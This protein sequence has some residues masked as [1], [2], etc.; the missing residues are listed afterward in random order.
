MAEFS[1]L[2][3]KMA[4]FTCN[5]SYRDE[6]NKNVK[7]CQPSAAD[8][9]ADQ[10]IDLRAEVR[11]L[12]DDMRDGMRVLRDDVRGDVQDVR[13][14]VVAVADAIQRLD[15]QTASIKAWL[16]ANE[17]RDKTNVDDVVFL[18][19]TWSTQMFELVAEDNAI[20][21][22]LYQLDRA[23]ADERVDLTTFLRV[24]RKL[25]HTQFMA[26]ALAV[27]VVERQREEYTKG[28]YAQSPQ[29][30]SVA[31]Q[32]RLSQPGGPWPQVPP[33]YAIQQQQF[34]SQPQSQFQ[35]QFQQHYP[36]QFQ[37]PYAQPIQ[38]G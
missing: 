38:V 7:K 12:R 26:R 11:I 30:S 14:G 32:A 35:P 34:Q 13:D 33:P 19:D 2:M 28:A 36:P 25:A 20:E 21:D 22:T 18:K 23:L 9:G 27:K 3:L 5:A 10:I 29:P 15:E 1:L 37:Q 17:S 16:D 8:V 4:A 24:V 6:T 31:T